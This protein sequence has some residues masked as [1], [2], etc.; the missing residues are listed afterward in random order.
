MVPV[1]FLKHGSWVLRGGNGA[2][3]G[4][5]I[6]HSTVSR[7]DMLKAY[8]GVHWWAKCLGAHRQPSISAVE[9]LGQVALWLTAAVGLG[10]AINIS[11]VG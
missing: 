10:M 8:R 1:S 7:R 2:G 5:G 9:G 4:R 11:A 6:K 3:K